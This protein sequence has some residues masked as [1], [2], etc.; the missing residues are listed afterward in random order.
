L[1]EGHQLLDLSSPQQSAV[2]KE[3]A[4]EAALRRMAWIGEYEQDRSSS[5]PARARRAT[6]D[7]VDKLLATCWP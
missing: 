1:P 5:R 7:T 6:A 4:L 2:P 3:M